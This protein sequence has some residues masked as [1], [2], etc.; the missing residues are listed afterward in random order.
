ML[1]LVDINGS[2]TNVLNIFQ[3][4]NSNGNDWTTATTRLQNT[5]DVSTQG[6]ID[7]NPA[8]GTWGL[9]LGSG[10]TEYMRLISGKVGIGTTAPGAALEVNGS[11]KLSA[12]SGGVITFADGT[13]QSTAASGVGGTRADRVLPLNA[14]L[15]RS[16]WQA[17]GKAGRR[18]RARIGS[19][20]PDVFIRR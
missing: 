14:H 17:A 9:A 1:S 10:S 8:G 7:F 6:Y 12:G 13:Q 19:Q 18:S 5:T 3:L 2:N 4:R 15:A 20:R 11:I 16:T